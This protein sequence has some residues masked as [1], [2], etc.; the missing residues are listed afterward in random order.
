MS[1]SFLCLYS[2]I[3]VF[4]S[5]MRHEKGHLKT[6]NHSCMTHFFQ[7]E[8]YTYCM[9]KLFCKLATLIGKETLTRE[10]TG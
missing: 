3:V 6:A 5:N 7:Q 9:R 8:M 2:I 1:Y 10:K 4:K